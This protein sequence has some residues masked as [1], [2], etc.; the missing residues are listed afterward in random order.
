M[1]SKSVFQPYDDSALKYFNLE[2]SPVYGVITSIKTQVIEDIRVTQD[3]TTYNNIEELLTT[4]TVDSQTFKAKKKAFVLPLCPATLVR[5]KSACKEHGITL[6]N[7]YTAADL[8][9][10]HDH[11]ARNLNSGETIPSSLLMS[12]LYNYKAYDKSDGKL[13]CVD[14][15]HVKVIHDGKFGHFSHSYYCGDGENLFDEWMITGMAMNIAHKID[16]DEVDI[17]D[18]NSIIHESAV[19]TALDEETINLITTLM[20][21]YNDDD[22]A[23]AAKMIPTIDYNSN[24]HLLWVL[25]DKIQNRIYKLNKDKDVQY[26]KEQSNFYKLCRMSAQDMILYLEQD[27]NLTKDSFCY[28][29]PICRQEIQIYNRDLYVFKVQVKQEY[30]KY[31]K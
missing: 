3:V 18:V 20:E 13:D 1:A 15:Y 28:L 12:K 6:T 10:S 2:D 22:L 16:I 17:I 11:V 26:W 30:I 5:I 25:A 9:I 8:I 29:E 24:H 31:L 4:N 19:K 21:S 23:I 27:D 14:N 7:D